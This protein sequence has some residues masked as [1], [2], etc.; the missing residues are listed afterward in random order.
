MLFYNNDIEINHK[1]KYNKNNYNP[2]NHSDN[3]NNYD[4]QFNFN[5][6][7]TKIDSIEEKIAEIKETNPF[8][9]PRKIRYKYPLIYNTNIFYYNQKNKRF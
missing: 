8:L 3:Y 4:K 6:L 2:Y 9:I 5:N 1:E 7:T